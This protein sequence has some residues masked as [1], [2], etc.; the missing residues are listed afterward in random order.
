MGDIFLLSDRICALFLTFTGKDT[1]VIPKTFT[2]GGCRLC[3]APSRLE[4]AVPNYLIS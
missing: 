4:K 2:R 1:L 3:E